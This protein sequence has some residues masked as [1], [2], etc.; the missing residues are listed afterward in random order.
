M[1]VLSRKVDESILI[2]DNIKIKIIGIENGNIKIGIDAPKE[3]SIARSELVDAVTQA[4]KDA[5][6]QVDAAILNS[7]SS[8]FNH[9]S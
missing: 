7:L 3:I 1:L 6:K 5:S 4:N 2:G 9:D 8:S